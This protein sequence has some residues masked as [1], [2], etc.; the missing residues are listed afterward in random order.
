MQPSTPFNILV[1]DDHALVREAFTTMLRVEFPH[2]R[3]LSAGTC[4]DAL[5]EARQCDFEIALVD[6]ELGDRSGTEGVAPAGSV[7]ACARS[8]S[9]RN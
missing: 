6:I 1:V 8:I 5:A 7:S 3:V 4:A 9:P 2:A